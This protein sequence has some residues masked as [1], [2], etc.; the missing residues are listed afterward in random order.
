MSNNA[1]TSVKISK[2]NELNSVEVKRILKFMIKNNQKLVEEGKK[3][4]ALSIEGEGGIGKTSVVH[5]IADEL[6]MPFIRLNL[7]EITVEDLLGYP[8]TEF[9]LC[10]P[11]D[12][13]SCT[14][15]SEKLI[16]HYLTL[17]YNSLNESRMG[18]ALPQWIV[19]HDE[20]TPVILFLDDA[21]R[22][23]LQLMQATMTLIDEQKFI[24]WGLPKGSTVI[25]STNPDDGSY[26]VTSTDDAQKTRYLQV[27]MKFD[28][29]C[30]ASEFAE[31]YKLD[32]RCT[33]F[34]LKN[35]EVVGG[36]NDF[37]EKGNKLKKANIRLWT[38]F[39]DTIS[40]IEDFEKDLDL[41]MN[42]ASASIPTEHWTLFAQFIA[43]KLDKLPSP[44]D[45]LDK[46]ETYVLNEMKS[47]I[48]P[49]EGRIRADIACVLSKRLMNYCVTNED[50][51]T[52]NQ[53]ER[54]S[55]ILESEIFPKDLLHLSLKKI[56]KSNKLKKIL[57][58]KNLI[59]EF[60]S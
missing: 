37:D 14:W 17:G 44:Q 11:N 10:K 42:I 18:Y 60:V 8:I 41:I 28:V 34:I 31:P 50:T 25:L 16:N 29:D 43:N 38:K 36:T 30:W 26:L 32:G 48:K 51:I 19:G 58:S 3:S 53:I 12:E 4:I 47:L 2:N 59:K 52:K 1:E 45:M 27:N 49:K 35:P 7:A 22:A 24:S 46:D 55:K 40:G 56:A 39:F 5:Q 57:Q 54:Y 6:N 21:T 23:T 33:N 20:N 13:N 15:V 9:K